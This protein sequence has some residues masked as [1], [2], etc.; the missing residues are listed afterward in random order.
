MVFGKKINIED[1]EG[2][3]VLWTT[4]LISKTRLEEK[5]WFKKRLK[6]V[7]KSF[8]PIAVNF[9]EMNT[10]LVLSTVF[11]EDFKKKT[12]ENEEYI[13][14]IEKNLE[15]VADGYAEKLLKK[16]CQEMK[17]NPEIK[18]FSN[19]FINLLK[20]DKKTQEKT[21]SNLLLNTLAEV[22]SDYIKV[23]KK[24]RNFFWDF[25]SK[26]KDQVILGGYRIDF[27]GTIE[28]LENIIDEAVI[29]SFFPL[30]Y[31]PTQKLIEKVEN[32][33]KKTN[34]FIDN[35]SKK[36]KISWDETLYQILQLIIGKIDGTYEITQK[37]KFQSVRM[38][39]IGQ[40]FK[41]ALEK[42]GELDVS[43][44]VQECDIS[45][46]TEE[47]GKNAEKIVEQ[48]LKT[49]KTT[50]NLSKKMKEAEKT[51]KQ[52]ETKEGEGEG[53]K[54]PPTPSSESWIPDEKMNE[55]V[56][57]LGELFLSL[58]ALRIWADN[59]D[60]IPYYTT[61]P[62]GV[63]FEREKQIAISLITREIPENIVLY[64]ENLF[65][66]YHLGKNTIYALRGVNI[67][68]KKGEFVA[69]VGTSGS[70]KTTLLNLLSGLD[71][72][73]RGQIYLNGKNIALLDDNTLSETRRD[74]IGFVFQTYNLIP[75]MT[76][77]ENVLFPADL[78]GKRGKKTEEKALQILETVGIKEYANQ[79]PERISG[80]QQQR[81]TIARALINDP[82]ILVADEPTGNL[83]SE[84]GRKIIDLFKKINK[85]RNVT[86]LMVTHDPQMAKQADYMLNMKDGQVINTN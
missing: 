45:R 65:K 5:E 67:T 54:K 62:G 64:G 76:V 31:Y 6:K 11:P 32:T 13:Q 22:E 33:I 34:T 25:P 37:I 43:K 63:A 52:K 57:K 1:L 70:G 40:D 80:G 38:K 79:Y 4:F 27:S 41:K 26:E 51:Q 44:M 53:E 73:E 9:N 35:Y 86:I 15:E 68:I 39:E 2:K 66:T 74:N 60:D 30:Y 75:E 10:F 42:E 82:T 19:I 23:L 81:V 14:K 56:V 85:E 78:A 29:F 8:K 72:P 7:I 3:T 55:I 83:D 24:A 48:I 59:W 12:G 17:E 21:L 16:Y 69:L 49:S 61:A 47:I 18:E 46:E 20:G 50:R 28:R 36:E 71:T 77:L 84:T 58:E